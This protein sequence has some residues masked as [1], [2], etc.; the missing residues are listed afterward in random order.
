M[1]NFILI[2]II[3]FGGSINACTTFSFS[4]KQGNIVFGRN[5]DFSCN[6]ADIF[7]GIFDTI[8]SINDF[9]EYTYEANYKL[10]EHVVLNVDF[11]K[12]NVTQEAI[13]AT[14]RYPETIICNKK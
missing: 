2:A 6:T 1:R 13:E 14:A 12:N 8:S 5:F 10:Q 11:L 3:F 4:D 9:R 7:A